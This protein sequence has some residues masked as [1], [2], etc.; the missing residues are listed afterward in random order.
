MGNRLSGEGGGRSI[1]GNDSVNEGQMRERSVQ[2]P[3]GDDLHY[4][5]NVT[6][7][8]GGGVKIRLNAIGQNRTGWKGLGIK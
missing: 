5:V 3:R 8:F 6:G 4:R 2:G 1:E 7:R